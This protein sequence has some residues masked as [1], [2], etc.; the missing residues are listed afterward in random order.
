MSVAQLNKAYVAGDYKKCY[1]LAVSAKLELAKSGMLIPDKSSKNADT[2]RTT[3]ERIALA[4]LRMS[5]DNTFART[6]EQLRVFYSLKKSGKAAKEYDE[7]SKIT[8][9]YLLLLLAKNDIAGFHTTLESLT[10]GGEDMAEI[11]SLD[12]Y[13]SYP[14]KLERWLMEGSY[15]SVWKATQGGEVP[16][17]EYAL[18]SP[19]LVEAIR[20]EVASCSER[21]YA[22]LPVASCR[23]LLFLD[24]DKEVADFA[25]AKGWTIKEG[26]VYFE[27]TSTE[28]ITVSESI[29]IENVIGYAR[30]LESIV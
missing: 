5:D 10:E 11:E 22:S 18:F 28:N 8:G 7:K 16:S 24:S 23:S 30:Q 6:F 4:A 12:P 25:A 27:F 19:I 2:A 21:A 29:I 13:L 1:E 17:E 15:G 26:R 20:N 9:L 14:V 3:L